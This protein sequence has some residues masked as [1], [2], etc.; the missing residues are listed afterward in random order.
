MKRLT[1]AI[2]TAKGLLSDVKEGDRFKLKEDLY[3][4]KRNA[5]FE[6]P[7]TEREFK[8]NF[9]I[10]KKGEVVEATPSRWG[11]AIVKY[12]GETYLIDDSVQGTVEIL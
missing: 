5:R 2:K 12:K 6:A 7:L 10:I 8:Q 3:A 4:Y 9:I 11:D 1:D